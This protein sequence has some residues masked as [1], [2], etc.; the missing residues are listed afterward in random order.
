[1]VGVLSAEWMAGAY[2][3]PYAHPYTFQNVTTNNEE[4]KPVECLCT[5]DQECGCDDNSDDKEYMSSIL[6]D[7]S[8]EGLNKTLVDVATINGTTTIVINGTL[9]NG[10][11]ASGG[12]EDAFSA[13]DGVRG[14][15]PA[16]GWWLIATTALAFARL[17]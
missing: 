17:V 3:Y 1:M 12:T 14:L 13:A 4:T 6:G 15:I 9:P 8:Y 7:G 5:I 16:M 11:T 10:T 2:C